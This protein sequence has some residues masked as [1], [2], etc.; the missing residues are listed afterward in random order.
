M[1]ITHNKLVR[2]NIPTIIEADGKSCK[3][4]ILSSS[5]YIVAL[6]KKLIEEAKEVVEAEDKEDLMRELADVMEIVNSIETYYQIDP[7]LVEEKRIAKGKKNGH[8]KDR[9]FLE[10]VVEKEK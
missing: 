5:E 3:T 9:I 1:K 2:D 6:K 4:S 10:Y 8:F 7:N